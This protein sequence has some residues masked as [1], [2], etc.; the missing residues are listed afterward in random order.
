M[1][2]QKFHYVNRQLTSPHQMY[3]YPEKYSS[4]NLYSIFHKIY[5][6]YE[7]AIQRLFFTCQ[8]PLTSVSATRFTA[9]SNSL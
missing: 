2:K 5:Q 3:N 6:K 1:L 8:L 7:V 4:G 9:V